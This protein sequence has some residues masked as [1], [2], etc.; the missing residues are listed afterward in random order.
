MRIPVIR[1][2]DFTDRDT[3]SAPGVVIINQEMVRRFWPTGD[4]LN[5]QLVIGKGMRREYDQEPLRQIVGIV[6]N[7]RDTTLGCRVRRG[8]RCTCRW[9]KSRTE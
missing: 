5:D 8:R 7:V 4:P 9:H 2:R 1:G 6:G 3:A